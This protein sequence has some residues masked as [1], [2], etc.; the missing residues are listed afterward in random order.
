MQCDDIS[1]CEYH[2]FF[3][4]IDVFVTVAVTGKL[5]HSLDV[6]LSTKSKPRQQAQVG[7]SLYV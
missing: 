2:L 7:S 6:F 1:S 4:A 5:M 3:F